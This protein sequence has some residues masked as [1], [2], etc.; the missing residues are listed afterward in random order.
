MQINDGLHALDGMRVAVVSGA[1][2]SQTRPRMIRRS[3]S[4]GAP[5]LPE[6]EDSTQTRSRSVRPRLAMA[7]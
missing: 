1:G 6:V 3:F 2:L 5:K 4:S 7:A